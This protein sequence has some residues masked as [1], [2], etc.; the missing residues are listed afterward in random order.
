MYVQ[1]LLYYQ[2]I[3]LN[4]IFISCIDNF[5]PLMPKKEETK[6]EGGKGKRRT[7]SQ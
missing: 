7:F 3:D 4:N 1:Y 6:Q 5:S 2:Q